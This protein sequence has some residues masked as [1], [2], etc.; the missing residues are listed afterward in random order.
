LTM[1][2]L[3]CGCLLYTVSP[4]QTL[5]R[6]CR[7]MQRHRTAIQRRQETPGRPHQSAT[8]RETAPVLRPSEDCS[9]LL[10]IHLG[11]QTSAL[12]LTGARKHQA[13]KR[14]CSFGSEADCIIVRVQWIGAVPCWISRCTKSGL[15]RPTSKGP[16]KAGNR[17]RGIFISARFD[18]VHFAQRRQLQI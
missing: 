1:S 2:A 14:R 11:S 15:G 7:F 4:A 16:L 12:P 13:L 8:G 9:G 18:R 6:Q 5:R 3:H 17:Y 10:P